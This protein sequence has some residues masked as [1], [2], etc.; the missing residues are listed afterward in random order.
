MVHFLNLKFFSNALFPLAY[1]QIG[2][3]CLR[4]VS[5]TGG[6]A[7]SLLITFPSELFARIWC[8]TADSLPLVARRKFSKRGKPPCQLGWL[9]LCSTVGMN[10][11][12]GQIKNDSTEMVQKEAVK[13]NGA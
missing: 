1:V 10:R 12:L 3:I 2:F 13:I 4:K 11:I 5:P 6:S 9:I 7:S 8:Y